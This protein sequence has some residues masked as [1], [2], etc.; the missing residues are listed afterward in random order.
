[1][2]K[3]GVVGE[4]LSDISLDAK[5]KSIRIT[6]IP[7]KQIE[8]NKKNGY[9]IKDVNALAADIKDTGLAQPLEVLA[10]GNGYRLITG[11]R[12]LTAIDS[13]IESG[14]WKTD[15]PC[16]VKELEDYDLPLSDDSKEMYAIIRTNRFTRNKSDA[17]L[18]FE[19]EEWTKIVQELKAAGKTV[20]QLGTDSNGNEVAIDLQGRTREV[21]ARTMGVSNGQM[22][23]VEFI[24]NHGISD[25]QEA[26]RD[27]RV[28]IAT[29][30]QIAALDSA[31]QEELLN[32]QSNQEI[33]DSGAVKAFKDKMKKNKKPKKQENAEQSVKTEVPIEKG[34]ITGK[35]PYGNCVCC[36][37]GGVQCC[38]QCDNDCNGRCGWLDTAVDKQTDAAMQ[39]KTAEQPEASGVINELQD[40]KKKVQKW[41]K[42]AEEEFDDP[43]TKRI[44]IEGLKKIICEI[45]GAED[46]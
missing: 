33:I 37:N 44:V 12:R 26:V 18:M 13:L 9:S 10:V 3:F 45:E 7:R 40:I 24:K 22:A 4:L 15:I 29:A 39:S 5:E 23:K 11:E 31:D 17:D 8:K 1:M 6:W 2:K 35:N 21:V 16:I 43:Q 30:H 25:L 46:E 32:Q 14:D 42:E 34:C 28:N 27:E 20:L 38:A 19:S 36:G 41:L